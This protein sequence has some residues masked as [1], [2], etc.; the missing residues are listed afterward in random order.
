MLTFSPLAAQ[1][2][3][4]PFNDI[5]KLPAC[6]VGCG[7][8]YDANGA[9]VPPA[10]KAG[11]PADWSKCL[12]YQEKLFPLVN[13]PAAVCPNACAG[14]PAG[15]TS[16]ASWYKTLCSDGPA[17]KTNPG[18]GNNNPQTTGAGTTSTG[19]PAPTVHPNLGES[20]GDWYVLRHT[21]LP[22]LPLANYCFLRLSNHW[23]W[24]VM[25]VIL[26]VGI[27]AIWIGACIWRRRY[28]RKKDRQTTLGQK[29][30]G[31]NSRP[32]WGPPPAAGLGDREQPDYSQF[33]REPL[34]SMTAA[35]DEKATR[36]SKRW[37][38]IQRT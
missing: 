34:P 10:V 12:C 24:V 4:I 23:Q 36:K 38:P 14:F 11:G 6:A 32:S 16:L 2:T 28:L 31:S 1:T 17:F 21:R 30:S 26:I 15:S 27:A 5:S 18:G 29:H 33:T 35:G 7:P 13:Q 19:I 37:N 9:C 22:P 20:N 8:L 3:I 25:L